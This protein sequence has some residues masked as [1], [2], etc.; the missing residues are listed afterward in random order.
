MH[1]IGT[2]IKFQ[3]LSPSPEKKLDFYDFG[4]QAVYV[5]E[6][7]RGVVHLLRLFQHHPCLLPEWN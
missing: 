5:L 4:T 3:L 1:P 7:R 6:G 2:S